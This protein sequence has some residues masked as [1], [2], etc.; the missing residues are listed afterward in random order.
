[1]IDWL[2]ERAADN[3]QV[4]EGVPPEDLLSTPETAVFDKLHS[5]KRRKDWLLGRLTAK[6][7][8]REVGQKAGSGR[9]ALSEISI[10]AAQDGAPEVWLGGERADFIL[11]ISHS[12]GIVFCAVVTPA[13]H[14]LGADIEA[15]EPRPPQFIKDYFTV[16]EKEFVGQVPPASRDCLVTAIWSGKESVFKALREG[17]R[18]DTRSVSCTF[19]SAVDLCVSK[20]L[21]TGW[22]PFSIHWPGF[23]DKITLPELA[24]WWRVW[25]DFVLTLVVSAE[26]QPALQLVGRRQP[27]SHISRYNLRRKHF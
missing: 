24:G 15:I 11:S 21:S 18:L 12:R 22:A 2:V 14:L 6:K 20:P 13:T 26:P 9:L 10:L 5:E 3:P 19:P 17:L 4:A 16:E 25:G 1:V 27:S 23:Q 7:L 8:V